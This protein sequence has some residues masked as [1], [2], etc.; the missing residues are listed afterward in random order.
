MSESESEKS[1]AEPITKGTQDAFEQ[2]EESSEDEEESKPPE[3][4]SKPKQMDFA[5][6]LSLR[7]AGK[8]PPTAPKAAKN[9]KEEEDKPLPSTESVIEKKEPPKEIK[10]PAISNIF[11]ESEDEGDNLFAPKPAT[12]LAKP[13]Q[14]SIFDNSDSEGDD[15]AP[16]SSTQTKK[17]TETVKVD[18]QSNPKFDFDDSEDETK[19]Q[20]KKPAST[21]TNKMLEEL[22]KRLGNKP[23]E[24]ESDDD[25]FEPKSLTQPVATTVPKPS[26]ES[27]PAPASSKP[28]T[29]KISIF[30]DDDDEDEDNVYSFL[31]KKKEEVEP[32][33]STVRISNLVKKTE[34]EVKKPSL[35]DDDE[36]ED[37]F[38][39]S[40]TSSSKPVENKVPAKSEEA[41][42][43]ESSNQEM[44]NPLQTVEKKDS[45]PSESQ[46]KKTNTESIVS[47][48]E[49]KKVQP[50]FPS[51]PS[52]FND[53]EDDIF[54]ISK[55]T[56]VT[57]P[58]SQKPEIEKKK[59]E[60][61]NVDAKAAGS[62]IINKKEEPKE[63]KPSNEPEPTQLMAP[64]P[65]KPA[66]NLLFDP[67]ALKASNLFKKVIVENKTDEPEEAKD[68]EELKTG[69][70]TTSFN[71]DL[72]DEPILVSISK[73]VDIKPKNDATAGDDF[74]EI[75]TDR[76][77][78]ETGMRS[79]QRVMLNSQDLNLK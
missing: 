46:V 43:N 52:L 13:S 71:F 45:Q 44:K 68:P 23:P 28:E 55:K 8:K 54:T 20:V 19:E 11:N 40:K 65:A 26:V 27:K 76:S 75:E 32:P 70:N 61:E 30:D 12:S 73:K 56:E 4:P 78:N 57:K 15:F 66:R 16:T 38:S 24:T 18:A 51:K 42:K 25:E 49:E 3:T 34:P 64:K 58:S 63:D 2:K 6:E 72:P 29:K 9:E 77:F 41:K 14:K 53:D 35:F 62:E 17:Q 37:L 7:L 5:T 21:S 79:A 22:N 10:K 60:E 59:I 33:K 74:F 67:S 36:D 48:K 31:S 1:D 50:V 39:P 69:A 47:V